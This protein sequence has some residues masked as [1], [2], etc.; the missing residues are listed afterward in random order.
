ML[1]DT[2]LLVDLDLIAHNL[3]ELRA[4]LDSGPPIGGKAPRI[5]AVL[6]ADAY[7]LGATRVASLLADEGVDLLAVACLSEAIEIRRVLRDMDI[8]VMGHSPSDQ[9]PELV[10]HNIIATIFDETQARALSRAALAIGRRARV[11]AKID[12]GMNRLGIKTG[13]DALGILLA[14]AGEPG[15]DVEGI[16]THLALD[17]EDS[18]RLQFSRFMEL[19]DG[20]QARGLRFRYRHVC[21]SIGLAR[22]PEFRLDLVRPGAILWGIVPNRAP[23]LD[24]RDFRLPLSFRSRISRLRT[25]DAGEGVGYDFSWKAPRGG[26]LLATVPAGYADGYPRNLSNVG[27]V[28]IRGRRAPVVG[29]VCMDQLTVDASSVPGVAE[30]DEVLLFGA[31]EGGGIDS[32]IPLLE[33]SKLASTN[34][35]DLIA[36]ISRRV[37]R[38]YRRDGRGAGHVDYVLGEETLHDQC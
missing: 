23:L 25:L 3:R 9:F 21:D 17:N 10:R 5:A 30:G 16:F 8:L 14:I 24:G 28:L 35:N 6:K 7:G 31:G 12:S 1:R 20:A 19:V 32:G 26:A 34:R 4:L 22:Y 36:S 2:R 38:V 37:P 33:T 13:S 15:L 29:L 18:D 27:E 11:H